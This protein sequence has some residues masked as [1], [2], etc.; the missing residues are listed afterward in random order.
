MNNQNEFNEIAAINKCRDMWLD[1]AEA[2]MIGVTALIEDDSFVR[3]IE[4]AKWTQEAFGYAIHVQD[5]IMAY[6]KIEDE[7]A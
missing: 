1:I 4:R 7:M 3:A 5:M 2:G 6:P